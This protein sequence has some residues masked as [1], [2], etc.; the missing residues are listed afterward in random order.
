MAR[1]DVVEGHGELPVRA[2]QRGRP[3]AALDPRDV[4][5]PDGPFADGTVSRPISSMSRR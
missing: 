5:D 4:V 2:L 1:R 3:E